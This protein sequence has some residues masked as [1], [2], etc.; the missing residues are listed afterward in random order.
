MLSFDAPK[1]VSLCQ[2]LHS[3]K[4]NTLYRQ[5]P[6]F[7]FICFYVVPLLWALWPLS[8]MLHVITLDH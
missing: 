5:A 1:V 8:P 2:S 7:L 6:D 4:V 3:P